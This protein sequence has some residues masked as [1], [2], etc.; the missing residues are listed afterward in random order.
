VRVVDVDID[1]GDAGD[2]GVHQGLA[3]WVWAVA[4]AVVEPGIGENELEGVG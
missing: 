4:V 2:G 3:G 1:R